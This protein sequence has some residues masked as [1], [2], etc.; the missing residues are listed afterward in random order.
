MKLL[1][2]I[3]WCSLLLAISHQIPPILI[4]AP[5]IIHVGVEESIAVQGSGGAQDQIMV[6][7]HFLNQKTNLKCSKDQTVTLNEGNGFV[8]IKNLKITPAE[9]KLCGIEQL[10]STKYVQLVANSPSLPGG[11]RVFHILLSTRR[12][13]LF[14][15]TDKS[16]Y[17]P[18]QKA[19]YRVFVL[20]H[21]MR[22]SS[23]SVTIS[24]FNAQGVQV[25]TK[26]Q[27]V[28][29][30]IINQEVIIP[31]IS[32]PGIW[33]ITAQFTSAPE[34]NSS[35]EFEVRKY[36]L[37][38]FE[39]KILPTVPYYDLKEKNFNFSVEAS[40]VYGER[41]SGVVYLRFGVTEEDG[42]RTF[43][44]GMEQQVKLDEGKV[45]VNLSS[46]EVSA[47]MAQP[48]NDLKGHSL[49]IA[50][51]VVELATGA[52][53][54]QE[55]STVKFVTSPYVVDLSK[56]KRYFVPGVPFLV[57]ATVTHVDGSPA[58][59]IP[60]RMS[61]TITEGSSPEPQPQITDE[62]GVVT[63]YVNLPGNAKSLAIEVAV[64]VGDSPEV[65]RTVVSQYTSKSGSY[66][67]INVPY[68]VV[69]PDEPLPI[70]LKDITTTNVKISYFYYMVLNK[71][72]ILSMQRVEHSEHTRIQLPITEKMIPAFRF[73]AY[74]HL[75]D[76]IVANSVWMDVVDSC[77]GKLLVS[78]DLKNNLLPGSPLKLKIETDDEASV[79]LAAVDSAVYILNKK[80]RLTPNKV[81]QAMNSY[82]LGC[83]V[84]SGKDFQSVFQDAGLA[85][86]SGTTSSS[87]RKGYGCESEPRRQ[88]R[89]LYFNRLT[90]EKAN[91]YNDSNQQRCCRDGMALLPRYMK[92]TCEQR[93]SRVRAGICRDTFLH[94]CSYA[95][96]LRKKSVPIRGLGRM[97]ADNEDE[98]F[99]DE[100]SVQSRTYFP[101]SWMWKT[102]TVKEKAIHTEYVPDSI[103][104]WEIQAV[105]M[106]VGRGICI[107]EP[108]KVKVFTPFHIY[109]RLPYSVKRFEQLEIR[110]VLYN[111]M[112]AD[113]DVKVH[114][115]KTEGICS[116]ATATGPK[117]QS[118]LVPAQSAIPVPFSIIPMGKLDLPVTV[119]ARGRMGLG[120]W[121]TK[122]LHIVREGIS[123]LEEKTYQLDS[124]IS[125]GRSL[126]ILG[127]IPS[128]LI[129]DAD[130]S[131]SVRI[132][133]DSALETV[134]NSLA[135]DGVSRLIRV[136][137][138]CAEQ[139]M[140]YMAPSVYAM[141]YLDET[142]QWINLSPER[143]IEALKNMESGYA[144][145]L[146]FQKADGSYGAWTHTP[147]STWLTAFVAKVLSLCR[148]Y[149]NVDENHIRKA[150]TFLLSK[151]NSSTGEFY[152][153]HPVYHRE[154]QGGV[155]GL[156]GDVTLTA[157]V[158]IAVHHTLPLHKEDPG[159]LRKSI[160][161]ATAFLQ[162]RLLGLSRPYAI[163]ISA[164]A[165]SLA[166]HDPAAKEE[167]HSILMDYATEIGDLNMLYWESDSKF[168]LEKEQKTDR[169]PSASSI[170]VEAT[171]YALMHMLQRNDMTAANKIVR[172]LTEQQN[173]GGGFKSTQDTVVAL[174]ALS[175]DWIRTFTNEA[176]NLGVTITSPGR[177]TEKKILLQKSTNQVQEELQFGLGNSLNVDVEGRGKG[178]LTILKLY[179][180][181]QVENN[182]CQH[183][184]LE[185]DVSGEV[186]YTKEI[187]EDY[188]YD[189]GEESAD[190]P[191]PRIQ[192]YDLRRQRRSTAKPEKTKD[193]SVS[194]TVCLSH[195]AQVKLSG[196]AIA[197]ITMLSGF[198]PSFEDLN[199]LKDL[200]DRYISHYEYQY[201]R[202]LLYFD[203]V[204]VERDCISFEASQ[205][206]PI[207]LLQPASAT[208]YDFYDPDQKCTV[209]YS[210]PSKS[211]LVSALCSEEV[212]QCAEGPCPH[213]R[214]TVEVNKKDTDPRLHH[215]CYSPRVKY[216]YKVMVTAS[217]EKDAFM[218]YEGRISTVLQ[219]T[220]DETVTEGA[221][222]YFIK[223]KACKMDLE[224]GKE[225]LIM[226]EDGDTYDPS[227]KLQYLLQS[228]SWV[229]ELLDENK[230]KST[231]LR[232]VCLQAKEFME[233]YQNNGCMV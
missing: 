172:W 14:I 49:Y 171:S 141:K 115:E 216:G 231:R 69:K 161:D 85:F 61:M 60:T 87:I 176:V 110:P 136:P 38:N 221:T 64:A 13:Y 24:I 25:F 213:K 129:P 112:D 173:Y 202:L 139:T 51:T 194:Y 59:K 219:Y 95:S 137:T 89:S 142:E 31:D 122:V 166:S 195:D 35:A 82:D 168:R 22:P 226:G 50:A 101:E 58:T 97:F 196:M 105:S 123:K 109:L 67:S 29:N 17:T 131:M 11:K 103:T 4:T 177:Q 66:L 68:K 48:L 190:E 175:Q 53:E 225:Y 36:V 133:A 147:S 77:H 100:G 37:P 30:S 188:D 70:D 47:A 86:D 94:C 210:A 120:D 145:I 41:V 201:G 180:V 200:S 114:M 127:E 174:E 55:L 155:G 102:I 62:S 9:M 140:I 76:E 52:L 98:D 227:G 74:Y 99:M 186:K 158:T 184:Q 146:T 88:K 40:Y 179:R 65:S 10:R 83:S 19:L 135:A 183:L 169:V 75:A 44:R 111:Y 228:T 204:P 1:L 156:E 119:E 32:E 203:K 23:E 209:S 116:P 205:K 152:D 223:R 56:T 57:V 149:M 164:Y 157:F 167:A 117:I 207:G 126:Q 84:G 79:S 230:C 181:L 118:V 18:S 27:V 138:G 21:M 71:G 3:V 39:V 130:F 128:N 106:S 5:N 182:T 165:L 154:M 153:P 160:K 163:A 81:F 151:Q 124:A 96:E 104:T 191:L 91:Q 54:E 125:R 34:S 206:V 212:C 199:R 214:K 33:R 220:K 63:F 192:W 42:K 148:E 20:D 185:V 197:D 80:N 208:L 7:M 218:V 178:T 193:K 8:Q 144:R 198:E 16:I 224:T 159:A 78:T 121:I 2:W 150:V 45:Q 170:S 143:K 12:G 132:S 217:A 113:L 90:Q 229:E 162:R 187:E 233:S 108:M 222:R 72:Q 28:K 232:N 6:T 93:A 211:K 15:Q 107:T 215:A 134:N 92:R 26:E 189:Y 43:L 73:V 46:A